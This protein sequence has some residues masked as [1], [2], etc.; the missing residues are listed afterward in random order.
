MPSAVGCLARGS[1]SPVAWS[2]A[3]P[4]GKSRPSARALPAAVLALPHARSRAC[5]S[6]KARTQRWTGPP[7]R[8]WR[9]RG[10]ASPASL[11]TAPT[12][13]MSAPGRSAPSPVGMASSAGVTPAWDPRPRGP[14]Q[15]TSASTCPSHRRCR[16]AGLGPVP[17]RRHSARC[18]PR[19]L[20]LQAR[21]QLPLLVLPW[22]GPSAGPA[23]SPQLQG[24]RRGQR[25]PVPA[26]GSTWSQQEPLTCEA[27]GGLT[28]RWLSGGPWARW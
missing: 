20:L 13:G 21:P 4:G 12:G 17:G 8:L 3:R 1:R 22:S 6:T 9:A 2:P 7:V 28:V 23:S 10:P 11:P 18:P 14:C 5:G 27:Q 26:A 19:K 16:A 25:S 15:L 24:P